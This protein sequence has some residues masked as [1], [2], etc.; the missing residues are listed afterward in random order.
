MF[1]WLSVI[2]LFPVEIISSK[3]NYRPKLKGDAVK[4]YLL[5]YCQQG[6]YLESVF[7]KSRV[8]PQRNIL[9]PVGR[10][11]AKSNFWTR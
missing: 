3:R 8:K 1:N 10:E 11:V 5:I 7:W 2:I 9:D 4:I 6:L